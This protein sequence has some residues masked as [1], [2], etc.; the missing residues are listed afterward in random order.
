[1]PRRWYSEMSWKCL[2]G[3]KPRDLYTGCLRVSARKQA[4]R[5]KRVQ[6]Q[7]T[8]DRTLQQVKETGVVKCCVFNLQS[9]AVPLT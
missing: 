1:M 2:F 3:T 5:K 9:T 6:Q 8:K 4:T 7:A